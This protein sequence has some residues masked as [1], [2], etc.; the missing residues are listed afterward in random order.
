MFQV[1]KKQKWGE[2][3]GKYLEVDTKVHTM[4]IINMKVSFM[5]MDK[6]TLKE[7]EVMDHGGSQQG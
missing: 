6:E 4:D 7:G 2:G 3:D 5:E 1:C